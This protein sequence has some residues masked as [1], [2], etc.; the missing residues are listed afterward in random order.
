L[1]I[2]PFGLNPIPGYLHLAISRAALSVWSFLLVLA[3]ING[4]QSWSANLSVPC[5][6][7]LLPEGIDDYRWLV[8]FQ[9]TFVRFLLTPLGGENRRL[10][11]CWFPIFPIQ[12]WMFI[13]C[14]SPAAHFPSKNGFC[15]AP[16]RAGFG[17]RTVS[18]IS[19]TV[20]VQLRFSKIV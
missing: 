3:I 8:V 18:I 6:K 1:I 9:R 19:R 2:W 13:F 4:I 17:N 20:R 7:Q 12:L 16:R 11:P 5:L 14:F 10:S 15:A